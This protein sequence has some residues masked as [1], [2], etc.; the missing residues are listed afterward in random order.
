[1]VNVIGDLVLV[2][3][4]HLDAAGAAIATVT[5]QAISVVFALFLLVK[6]ELPFNK[7]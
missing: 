2:A 4:F 6:K 7:I 5:A 3:G 1:M